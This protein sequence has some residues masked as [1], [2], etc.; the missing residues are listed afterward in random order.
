[1]APTLSGLL[2]LAISRTRELDADLGAVELV[3]DLVGLASALRK[4]EQ[5]TNVLQGILSP[6]YHQRGPYLLRTHPQTEQR[7]DRLLALAKDE[8]LR[9]QQTL[10]HTW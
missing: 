5:H 4:I 3:G 7:V 10:V 6:G 9:T 8:P 1:L 2:R